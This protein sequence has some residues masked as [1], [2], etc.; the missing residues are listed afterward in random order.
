MMKKLLVIICCAAICA[1]LAPG[2][3]GAAYCDARL[4]GDADG[5]G[6]IT[7]ADA[8]A[9]LRV[10]AE[11]DPEPEA[12]TPEYFVMKLTGDDVPGVTMEDVRLVKRLSLGMED[13]G[14]Y[15]TKAELLSLFNTLADQVKSTDHVNDSRMT[16]FR[17]VRQKISVP[18]GESGAITRMFASM[19]LGSDSADETVCSG[20]VV[21]QP[22]NYY[23]GYPV[24]GEFFVSM[25]TPEDVTSV[26]MEEGKTAGLLSKYPDTIEGGDISAYKAVS[27]EGLLKLTVN[28]KSESYT[29][30]KAAGVGQPALT[31]VHETNVFDDFD[32]YNVTAE[33]Q[34]RGVSVRAEL[35]CTEI[36]TSATVEYWFQP[37]TLAPVAAKYT[38][39]E[40]V[41]MNTDFTL[42]YSGVTEQESSP[43]RLENTAEEL[44][45]FTPFI[46][47]ASAG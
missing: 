39:R 15:Y 42:S 4:K 29:Q 37:G 45:L 13:A 28:V 22:I 20:L 23:F 2:A 1:A 17:S 40:T 6:R 27:L 11:L 14:A 32:A 25:L 47:A 3:S 36:V 30:L 18:S 46:T 38:V 12:G 44:Y 9:I 8:R 16:S 10:C 35:Q 21:D 26:V 31:R 19:I 5:D 24:R 7:S 34:E 43:V 33:G 41:D